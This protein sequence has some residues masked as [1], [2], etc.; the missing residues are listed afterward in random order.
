MSY[1][2]VNIEKTALEFDQ[3]DL[4]RHLT[5]NGE[6]VDQYTLDLIT[7]LT[8]ECR[9]LMVPQGGFVTRDALLGRNP[10]EIC[11]PGLHFLTGKSIVKMLKGASRFFFFI[12]TIGPGPENLARKLMEKGQFLEGYITDLIASNLV[13]SSAQY[14]QDHIKDRLALEGLK[15]TNRY[16]PGYC[17]WE[18]DE[19]EKLFSLFPEG[20]CGITLSASSLMSP[21][22][23][24]SSLLGAGPTVSFRDYNCELCS[25][26]DCNFR[27]TR[28]PDG[29][30]K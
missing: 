19:Q 23:S 14:V 15:I 9:E 28:P 29:K 8:G 6:A 12:T 21:I 2:A 1:T 26:K 10:G 7:E 5:G 11:I 25:M 22:K 24:L 18:V 4:H 20:S 13:E 30:S 17:G 27:K 16:S 3:A